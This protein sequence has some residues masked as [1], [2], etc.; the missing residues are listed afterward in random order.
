MTWREG[1]LRAARSGRWKGAIIGTPCNS[2]TRLIFNSHSGVSPRLRH[3][4]HPDGVPG[5]DRRASFRLDTA[6]IQLRFLCDLLRALDA[7]GTR[8]IV[9]NPYAA[10][11]PAFEGHIFL[12]DHPAVAAL[13]RELG[14]V[15]IVTD[16]CWAFPWT[17]GAAGERATCDGSQ[18]PTHYNC[19]ALYPTRPK[20]IQPRDL[21][22]VMHRSPTDPTRLPDQLCAEYAPYTGGGGGGGSGLVPAYWVERYE[23]EAGKNWELFYR[24]NR[25][26]FF[27]DRH[28]LQAE[29][30]D[31]LAPDGGSGEAAEAAAGVA[32]DAAAEAAA[33]A[34]EAEE[35]TACRA[36]LSQASLGGGSGVRVLLEAGCGVGNALFPLLPATD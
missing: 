7:S 11:D 32:A 3:R 28:Y 14:A 6:N 35:L 34:P 1:A 36:Q 12:F 15:L 13:A 20:D 18:K 4:D 2:W 16:Q 5:L 24:R 10:P 17:D 9:E 31:E 26:R 8:W 25:D 30:A 29:W 22:P 19:R 27:K 33:E 23:R 21:R